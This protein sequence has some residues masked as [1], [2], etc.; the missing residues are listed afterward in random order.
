MMR[1]AAKPFHAEAQ[2][3]GMDDQDWKSEDGTGPVP[4]P[5]ELFGLRE[6]TIPS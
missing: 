4:G 2:R 3:T 1:K 6:T 5:V